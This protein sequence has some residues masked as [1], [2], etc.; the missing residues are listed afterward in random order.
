[1]RMLDIRPC[2]DV[3]W[4]TAL[5]VRDVEDEHLVHHRH[6]HDQEQRT[7]GGGHGLNFGFNLPL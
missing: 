5:V 7:C 1:M 3:G 6:R 2:G 4:W